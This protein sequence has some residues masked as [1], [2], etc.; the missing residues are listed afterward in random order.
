MRS[1]FF[2]AVGAIADIRSYLFN[3]NYLLFCELGKFAS[4]SAYVA[5]FCYLVGIV[6][7]VCTKE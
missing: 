4:I 2:G 6:G 3:R 5:V 1:D 7:E